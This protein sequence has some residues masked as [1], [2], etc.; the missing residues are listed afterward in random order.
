MIYPSISEEMATQYS[1]NLSSD[2]KKMDIVIDINSS[3]DI[4][5]KGLRNYKDAQEFAEHLDNLKS[6]KKANVESFAV[7][8]ITP[9]DWASYPVVEHL[10]NL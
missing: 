5:I 7:S 10:K 1:L 4:K 8:P 2:E 3:I 6:N 9:S